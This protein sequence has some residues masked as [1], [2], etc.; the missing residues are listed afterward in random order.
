MSTA[1]M[2]NLDELVRRL[3]AR[4]KGSASR[5][6][7][8]DWRAAEAIEALQAR[9]AELEQENGRLQAAKPDLAT[10]A[11]DAVSLESAGTSSEASTFMARALS[12]QDAADLL[13][14]SYGTV[15]ENRRKLGF[16]QVGRQW[17]IWP[18]VLRETLK[19]RAEPQER[20]SYR[21]DGTLP[22]DSISREAVGR[23]VDPQKAA[24]E[25]DELLATLKD[26]SRKRP[27]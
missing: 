3:R 17:R 18:D 15:F 16:T 14:V 7:S 25:F 10:T 4:M 26:K 23:I 6:R 20:R 2:D 27:R 24:R 19:S 21:V 9:V 11:R 22:R 5:E 8:L 12:L 1:S 13:G